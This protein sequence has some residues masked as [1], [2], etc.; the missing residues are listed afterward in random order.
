VF[1]ISQRL[2]DL[3]LDEYGGDV[4]VDSIGSGA[5]FER[6]C[7]NVESDIS[8][9]SDPMPQNRIEECVAN[10]LDVIEF[11]IAF[12]PLAVAVSRDNDF[13]ENLTLEQLRTAFSLGTAGTWADV[14]PSFPA[15]P[16]QLYSPG[17]DSGTFTFFVEHVMDDNPQLLVDAEG[18]GLSEDDNVLV[19][20]IIGSPYAIG[21]FGFAYYLENIETLRTISIDGVNPE[22]PEG[23]SYALNRPLFLY[24]APSVL[25]SKPQVAAFINYYLTVVD[26]QLLGGGSNEPIGYNPT[27]QYQA[28]F[29]RL[30]FLAALG[31]GM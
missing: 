18:I 4:T 20:G 5:G 30:Q 9:A 15:E 23:Q 2:A 12:D 11:V 22:N 24:T 17:T 19:Q 25:Q 29:N 8:N 28:A 27:G 16:I 3:Y 14:D 10:G 7:V 26:S 31:G 1:P 13:V 6:F 21:Y